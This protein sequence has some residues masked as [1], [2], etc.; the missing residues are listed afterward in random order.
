MFAFVCFFSYVIDKNV[1]MLGSGR[2]LAGFDCTYL[3]Q[4]LC[5]HVHGDGNVT[6]VGGPWSFENPSRASADLKDCGDI[7]SLKKATEM[8]LEMF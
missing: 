8:S 3:F 1:N 7:Q 4:T 5:Q 6:L 2:L